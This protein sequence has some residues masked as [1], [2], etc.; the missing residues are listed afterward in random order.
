M[1]DWK[2]NHMNKNGVCLFGQLQVAQMPQ[3]PS[4]GAGNTPTRG[5]EENCKGIFKLQHEIIDCKF[6]ISNN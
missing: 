1:K 4:S 2:L 3:H 5:K 6:Q